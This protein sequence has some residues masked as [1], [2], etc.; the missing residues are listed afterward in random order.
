MNK[1][2]RE[3]LLKVNVWVTIFSLAISMTALFYASYAWFAMNRSADTAGPKITID[4]G[5]EYNLKYFIH[6]LDGGYPRKGHEPV[7]VVAT[8][9][10][11]EFLDVDAGFHDPENY[12][13]IEEPGYHITFALEITSLPSGADHNVTFTLNGFDSPASIEFFEYDDAADEVYDITLANAIN[14][15]TATHV[16]TAADNDTTITGYVNDFIGSTSHTD[17]FDGVSQVTLLDTSPD[18]S[19][20]SDAT[21]LI[22]FFT[23]EFGDTPE[24]FYRFITLHEGLVY[25]RKDVTGNSNVYKGLSFVIEEILVRKEYKN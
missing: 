18:V 5:L 23:I 6:N 11:N 13:L 24:T 1:K 14:I 10:A 8:S 19:A 22:F 9:Y 17:K 7:D 16:L 21:S 25:F 2:K 20:S 15:Y 12:T 4:Q 3:K